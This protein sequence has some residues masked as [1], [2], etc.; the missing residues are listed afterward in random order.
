MKIS[1][2]ELLE[3]PKAKRSKQDFDFLL[4]GFHGNNLADVF[5]IHSWNSLNSMTEVFDD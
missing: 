5:L 4:S 3:N 1:K 2:A